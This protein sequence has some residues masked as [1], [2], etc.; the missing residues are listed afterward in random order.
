MH[1]YACLRAVFVYVVPLVASSWLLRGSFVALLWLLCDSIAAS[2]GFSVARLWVAPLGLPAPLWR[3]LPL[4]L[5]L[6]VAPCVDVACLR[7]K[8]SCLDVVVPRWSSMTFVYFIGEQE[9]SR[10]W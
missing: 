5:W 3:P 10:R 6:L 8:Y 9:S 4:L 1:V 2:P 7:A